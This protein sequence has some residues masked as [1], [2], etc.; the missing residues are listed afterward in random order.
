MSPNA[1]PARSMDDPIETPRLLLMSVT[2]ETLRAELN[3]T[4]LAQIGG[5][6][7]PETWPPPDWDQ[8]A[9]AYLLERMRRFPQFR[10]WCR[11]IAVKQPDGAMPLLIGGC[12]CTEPPQCVSEVEIGYAILPN[13]QRRGY[14][15][16]AVRALLPWIFSHANVESICAQ[17]YP[18]LAASIGV[19]RKCGFML[20]GTGKDP[21]TIMFRLRR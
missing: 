10:G 21:G 3:G 11:Y 17:T 9:I 12:G 16:E 20:D 7:V 15:T 1:R 13:Y 18:H 14:V 4:D 19:L 6:E 2:E 5:I 8:Q